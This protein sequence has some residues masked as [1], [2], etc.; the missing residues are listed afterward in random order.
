MTLSVC[1]QTVL[2]S[3]DVL[4]RELGLTELKRDGD[5]FLK[6]T[7]PSMADFSGHV[8]VF[9][10]HAEI[11]RMVSTSLYVPA[12]KSQTHMVFCFARPGSLVPHFT[13]DT[14]D[15]GERIAFHL[16]LIPRAP[17]A[18]NL[19][20]MRSV[21]APLTAVFEEI[22]Y[23]ERFQ[24]VRITPEQR[25]VMSPW[26]LVKYAPLDVY[27][28]IMTRTIPAYRTR[29]VELLNT[30]GSLSAT[31]TTKGTDA[32]QRAALFDPTVDPVWPRLD[33][34]VGPELSARVRG[35]LAG[36]AL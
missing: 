21:Y 2:E 33:R 16:D 28:E 24:T 6:L 34:M 20:Y 9:Q 27:P 25:A 29:F 14:A 32:A 22:E 4:S 1:E 8:R 31:H 7:S 35:L 5:V 19:D 12:R 36:E 15:H 17:V 10:G 11:D 3:V 30:A 13:V 18:P 23:G 26:M